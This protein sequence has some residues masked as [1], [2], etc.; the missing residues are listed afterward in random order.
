MHMVKRGRDKSPRCWNC[1]CALKYGQAFCVDCI[2]AIVVA[3]VVGIVL[4]YL[5]FK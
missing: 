2:R 5:G 3:L 4:G 1:K